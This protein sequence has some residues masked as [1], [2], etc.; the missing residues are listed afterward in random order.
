MLEIKETQYGKIAYQQSEDLKREVYNKPTK[1][2]YSIKT[3]KKFN[4]NITD[5]VVLNFKFLS[6]GKNNIK[7][8]LNFILSEQNTTNNFNLLI[9]INNIK[10]EQVYV[11]IENLQ[12]FNYNLEFFATDKNVIDIVLN[13]QSQ[14][15]N[16]LMFN[17]TVSG[18][19]SIDD[20]NYND[21]IL[22]SSNDNNSIILLY[23]NNEEYNSYNYINTQNLIDNFKPNQEGTLISDILSVCYNIENSNGYR[24]KKLYALYNNNNSLILSDYDKTQSVIASESIPQS[25]MIQGLYSSIANLL[26]CEVENQL[27][28]YKAYNNNLNVMVQGETQLSLKNRVKKLVPIYKKDLSYSEQADIM[29]ISTKNEVFIINIT[30]GKDDASYEIGQTPVYLGNASDAYAILKNNTLHIFMLNNNEVK[31]CLYTYY[32]SAKHYKKVSVKTF[33]NA[34]L[35]F[36]TGEEIPFYYYL[37]NFDLEQ[38]YE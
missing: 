16:F 14:P 35:G 1:Y 29:F 2:D 28:K 20:V 34:K 36:I 8:N 3:F 11:N 18:V 33:Y 21:Y 26:Y 24:N 25:Y 5:D 12:Q 7:L 4:L 9:K 22:E 32:D 38:S 6:S 13:S 19:F 27:L 23:K 37:N 31:H 17:C 10:Y 30:A 15:V